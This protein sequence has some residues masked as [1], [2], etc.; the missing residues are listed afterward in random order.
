MGEE[1]VGSVAHYFGNISVAALQLT[2]KLKIGD[3]IHIKGH[4]TD[5]MQEVESM[6]VEHG[7]VEEAGPGDDVAIEVKDTVREHDQVFVVTPD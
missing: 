1:A 4:T 2:G 3:T 5:F 7:P 6:Q